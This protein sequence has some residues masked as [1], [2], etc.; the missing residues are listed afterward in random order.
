[1]PGRG[2]FPLMVSS[3]L[4]VLGAAMVVRAQFTKR[5]PAEFNVKNI[6]IILGSLA[7]FALLSAYVNMIAG[8]VAL[9]FVSHSRAQDYSVRR[10]LK[11]SAV[12]IGIA[13][14]FQNWPRP[15][16]AALLMDI[17]HN[18]AFGFEHAL[19]LQNLMFCAI[20]CMVGT[21]VGLLPG[22]GPL[23]TISLL[24]PLTYL[25]PHRRRADH[26]GGHLLRRAV[27]RQRERHHDEDPAREQH[28]G[29]HRRLPDDAQGQDRP[30]AVHRRRFELHRRHGRDRRARGS[31]PRP[32]ARWRS[33]SGPRTTAR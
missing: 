22:L 27:R 19:T 3:I 8:I 24:L 14:A 15:P 10:N 4:F 25:D 30:G 12:L 26:A 9:V 20:G 32:W 5:V 33:C 7:A 21:L 18:L 6:A 17:L 16:P 23:A 28:R 11:I 2:F 31:A 13:F 29:V 1:M